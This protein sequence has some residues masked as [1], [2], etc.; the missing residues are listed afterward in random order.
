MTLGIGSEKNPNRSRSMGAR[1]LHVAELGRGGG[2]RVFCKNAL[3]VKGSRDGGA[4]GDGG[5]SVCD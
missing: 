1:W 4:L 2:L 5:V 3:S